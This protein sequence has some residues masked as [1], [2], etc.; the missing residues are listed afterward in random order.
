MPTIHRSKP[1]KAG[2]PLFLATIAIT[3]QGPISFM[4]DYMNMTNSSVIHVIDRC[5]A[6]PNCAVEILKIYMSYKFVRTETFVIH[7]VGLLCAL[8]AFMKSQEAQS[9]LDA[10]GFIFWH[11]TWH[12]IPL[13]T[14]VLNVYEYVI[15]GE[16]DVSIPSKKTTSKYA[17][18]SSGPVL[19]S[20]VVMKKTLDGSMQSNGTVTNSIR[21]RRPTRKE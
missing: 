13:T 6:L 21:R 11:N 1:K 17:N 19:L 7:A 18:D 9:N 5:L 4:A 14:I 20:S 12:I 2:F 3:V 10:D 15:C 8:Y 16:L